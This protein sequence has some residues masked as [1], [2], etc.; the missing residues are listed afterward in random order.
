MTYT[1]KLKFMS[2]GL[3]KADLVRQGTG[4]LLDFQSHEDPSS[5]LQVALIR[6]DAQAM[7]SGLRELVAQL[8]LAVDGP[9]GPARPMQ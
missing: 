2:S 9:T 8:Q 5:A 4:L 1:V 7:L 6:A 3:R